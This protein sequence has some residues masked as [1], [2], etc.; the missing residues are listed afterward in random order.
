MTEDN[1]EELIT[2]KTLK[3]EVYSCPA[4]I[5]QL[6]QLKLQPPD[7]RYALIVK[8]ESIYVYNKK[9]DKFYHFFK[10]DNLSFNEINVA[11]ALMI[12]FTDKDDTWI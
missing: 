11:F 8:Q 10:K 7:D 12:M 9:R 5:I 3:G 1:L 2:I 4:T 6:E